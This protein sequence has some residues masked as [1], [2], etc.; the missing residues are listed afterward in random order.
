MNAT[1]CPVC[2]EALGPPN[3]ATCMGCQRDFHLQMRTDVP[4]KD[5][6][7]AWLHEFHMHLVF[8]C[9]ECVE[10][11]AFVEPGGARGAF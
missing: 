5:C 4:G 10:A 9:R 1:V 7:D 6:G 8:G 11:G 2:E 3:V